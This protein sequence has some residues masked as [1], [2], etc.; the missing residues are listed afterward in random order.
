MKF[1]K[2]RI[3]KISTYY[4]QNIVLNS[5]VTKMVLMQNL[6]A[7]SD[8]FSIYRNCIHISFAQRG[9]RVIDISVQQECELCWGCLFHP[10]S[11][12]SF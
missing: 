8:R 2:T 6:E 11:T 3:I 12:A 4:V 9:N 5:T 10:L 1:D 7:L